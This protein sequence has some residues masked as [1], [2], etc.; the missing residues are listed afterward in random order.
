[1]DEIDD[2]VLQVNAWQ[3]ENEGWNCIEKGAGAIGKAAL[4]PNAVIDG[5]ENLVVG[6]ETRSIFGLTAFIE[7]T[8][9]HV[10]YIHVLAWVREFFSTNPIPYQ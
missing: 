6:L 9:I 7:F 3:A 2:A 10:W 4:G 5:F 1:M 8:N